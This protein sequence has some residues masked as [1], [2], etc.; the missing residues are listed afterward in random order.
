MP[1]F[2]ANPRSLSISLHEDLVK[3][4]KDQTLRLPKRTALYDF[5]LNVDWA[6]MLW[7]RQFVFNK[8]NV[9]WRAH[10]RLDS[11]PQFNRNY[12]VGEVDWIDLSN[13][14]S[15]L[16]ET[17]LQDVDIKV[18][19][20]PLQILGKAATSTAF[21]ARATLRMLSLESDVEVSRLR[22]YSL[23]SDF[24][25]EAGLWNL[26]NITGSS[27]SVPAESDKCFPASMPL[28]DID[29]MLHHCML[30]GEEAFALDNEF[31]QG[32]N[33]QIQALSKCF[34]KRDHCEKYI[35]THI[36][37]SNK[38]P[39]QFQRALQGMFS[40]TCPTFCQTRWHLGFDV[41]HWI[42]KRE[43]VIDYLHVQAGS[44]E[45]I[46]PAEAAA[47]KLLSDSVEERLKFWGT[48]WLYFV[49]QAWGFAVHCFMHKCSCPH[50]QNTGE[51]LKEP[52]KLN[53]RRMI[54][55]ACG[56]C[57][58][59]LQSLRRLTPESNA[60][61]V[62]AL[63]ALR[64][65]G[66]PEVAD[67]LLHHFVKAKAAM[68]LR[69]EQGTSYYQ[70]FPWCMPRLLNY[71]LVSAD[72]DERRAS[73]IRR[74]REFALELLQMRE[75]GALEQNTF[76]EKFFSDVRLLKSLQE[77]GSDHAS[78]MDNA[79]FKELLAYGL[80]LNAMQRLESRHHLVHQKAAPA[81][82]SSAAYISA[83]LRRKQNSDVLQPSFR[84][85]FESFLDNFS[86]LVPETWRSRCELI[87]LVSGHSLSIMFADVT[88][89]EERIVATTVPA[90]V[91]VEN[92]LTYQEH[93][94]VALRPGHHYAIPTHLSNDGATTYA[95][96]QLVDTRP[97]NKKYMQRAMGWADVW[98][99]HVAVLLLGKHVQPGSITIDSDGEIE[100]SALA[101]A[102]LPSDFTFVAG[103][104]GVDTIPLDTFF[105]YD[106]DHIY[107]LEASHSCAF[108]TDVISSALEDESALETLDLA[109]VCPA[110]IAQVKLSWVK[111][112]Q[113]GSAV[114]NIHYIQFY[115]YS[116]RLTLLHIYNVI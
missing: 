9:E 12:L 22:I 3:H 92:A 94:K 36:V 2:L 63:Q 41:M 24:G 107:R 67:S 96:A 17:A 11:S 69:F 51:K 37:G 50:H 90:R 97:A 87:K 106:F 10:L 38:V 81:R 58:E 68:M 48:F 44:G 71:L 108:A 4:L 102:P 53:G 57:A 88:W 73:A 86:Q 83:N 109:I 104:C 39:A 75:N 34:S 91:R 26:P 15:S 66:H 77:W 61:A 43:A 60:K 42:S 110:R 54:E 105:K 18:R 100:S 46:T 113:A 103:N 98:H 33:N 70:K 59:F 6:S 8:D 1:R 115:S 32:F 62:S 80:S 114:A 84:L 52:C 49:L 116:L 13:V 64:S 21:K 74:S 56:K 25:V 35:Q 55:L 47:V 45:D 65:A 82:A 16:P 78:V 76:A 111:L 19:L 99:D 7:A 31:W 40:S 72:D 27:G 101:L 95:L 5:R 20:L 14:S 29:H 89:E 30:D 93:L 79:L 23:L 28:N 112:S 85:N